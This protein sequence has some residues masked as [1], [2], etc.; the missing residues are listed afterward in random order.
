MKKI[1]QRLT[2]HQK[3]T[4][5]EAK[6][7]LTAISNGEHNHSQIASFMTVFMMRAI[8]VDELAGF[9]D[10]LQELY[11]PVDMRDFNAIDVCGT[12]GDGKDTFNISTLASLV[13]AGA[14]E[15]VTKHGNYGVSSSCGSSNV[16]EYL[17]YQFTNN[18]DI[19]RKQV[20]TAGI[21]FMHA[22]LF[23]PAMKEVAPIRR[24]LGVK[25]FFNILGPLINPASPKNQLA[26]VFNLVTARLYN[27]ILQDTDKR[28]VILHSLDGYDEISL[29]S[30]FKSITND[31]EFLH[32]PEDLGFSRV[33]PDELLGGASIKESARIFTNILEG[34]GTKA[35]NSA[36]IANSAM[37]LKCFD[38]TQPMEY[39]IERAEKS[40]TDKKALEVLSKVCN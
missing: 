26:G 21:C 30:D 23:H 11:L 1:L 22:P 10:A 20:D 19:L 2:A 8:T 24:E 15:K 37:A 40:L 18:T 32:S 34:K 28:F 35:Q 25:T 5:Q 29:T 17:G 38:Q 6:S 31:G 3:L 36:V 14:G 16:M 9:K 7:V 27:Y 13:V 12:G 33:Q 39:C 4:R